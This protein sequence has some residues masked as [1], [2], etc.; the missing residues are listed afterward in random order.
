[1]STAAELPLTLVW[2]ALLRR[3][4]CS[5][6]ASRGVETEAEVVKYLLVGADAVMTASAL[7]RNGVEHI[8]RM[9]S[10]LERWLGENGFGSVDAIR[11]LKDGTHLENLD[12][13]LRAQYVDAL[14]DYVPAKLVS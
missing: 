9:R 5:L 1:L 12:V 11:G 6:A 2:I 10:G 13:L 3:V 4:G 7:I 8:G 14:R